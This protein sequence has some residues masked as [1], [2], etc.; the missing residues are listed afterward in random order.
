MPRTASPDLQPF[1]TLTEGWDG[2]VNI[3]DAWNK[4]APNEARILENCILDE[5]GG[6][7]K[8]SGCQSQG[9]I[10]VGADRI[11]SLYTFYR[12]GSAPQVIAHTTAGK[13]YYTND[14][15]IAAAT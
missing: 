6:A 2:G 5:K 4:L 3:R 9:T 11:I 7:S 10:G 1:S 15:T 8:R 14:P 12:A 13:L